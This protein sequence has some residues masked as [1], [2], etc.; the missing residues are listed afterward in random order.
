MVASSDEFVVKLPKASVDALVA[1]GA[2]ERFDANR[3]QPMKE[4]FKV[5]SESAENGSR[6]RVRRSSSWGPEVRELM[7]GRAAPT[8]AAAGTLLLIDDGT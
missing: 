4:W 3:G 1:T 5:R 2:G 6:L 8:S 7:L